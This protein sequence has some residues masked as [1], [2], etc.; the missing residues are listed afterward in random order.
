MAMSKKNPGNHNSRKKPVSQKRVAIVLASLVGTLTF[1]SALLLVMESGPLGATP[2]VAAVTISSVRQAIQTS[3]PLRQDLWEYIV[4]YQS[5]G[6]AAGAAD[7]AEGRLKGGNSVV[8]RQARPDG[9]HF[10]I[11]NGKDRGSIDGELQ[12]GSSWVNQHFGAPHPG[13][14]NPRYY[15][16]PYHNAIGICLQADLRNKPASEAQLRSLIQLVNELNRAGLGRK[17]VIFQWER[18]YPGSP[19]ASPAQVEFTQ[20]FRRISSKSAA[21]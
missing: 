4:V 7:L 12:K 3:S 19:D 10:V 17:G 16:N 14:P 20:D 21:F 5:G 18:V 8:E 11:A 13:W 15:H 2:P 6:V 1:S 9:F